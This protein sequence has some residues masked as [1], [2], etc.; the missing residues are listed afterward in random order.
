M[1]EHI[2]CI[3]LASEALTLTPTR[4]INLCHH[5]RYQATIPGPEVSLTNM[6]YNIKIYITEI[7]HEI[8]PHLWREKKVRSYLKYVITVSV[9][10]QI[11]SDVRDVHSS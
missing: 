5:H 10:S 3:I 1:L 11:F 6:S 7:E 9:R 8:E 4:M 2:L